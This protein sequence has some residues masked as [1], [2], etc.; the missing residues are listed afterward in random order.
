MLHLT[1]ILAAVPVLLAQ[2]GMVKSMLGFGIVLL[3]L[4]LGLL[5]VCRPSGRKGADGKK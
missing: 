2:T 5:V 3:A 4:I 1:N